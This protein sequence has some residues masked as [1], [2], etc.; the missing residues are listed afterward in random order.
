MFDWLDYN[1]CIC[2]ASDCGT[3]QSPIDGMVDTSGTTFGATATYSCL[4]G[5]YVIGEATRTCDNSG[6]WSG[7]PPICR[8]MCNLL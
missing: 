2:V 7:V 1:Y 5:F 6:V 4:P 3:L 8:R